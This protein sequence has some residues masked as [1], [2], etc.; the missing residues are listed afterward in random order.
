[1][2]QGDTLIDGIHFMQKYEKSYDSESSAPDHWRATGW[3]LGQ[4]GDKLYHYCTA[5]TYYGKKWMFMDLDFSLPAGDSI[6]VDA[7]IWDP[8]LYDIMAVSDTML[9]S[10]TDRVVRHYMKVKSAWH[11]FLTDDIWIEGIGSVTTGVDYAVLGLTIGG[12][13]QLAKC[14]VG[15]QI[16]YDHPFDQQIPLMVE[17]VVGNLKDDAVYDLQGRCLSEKPRRGLYIQDGRKY[18]AD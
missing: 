8:W 1:M 9:D 12:F 11:E 14:F 3:Y 5:D 16:L 18:V 2:L 6:E 17:K 13:S 4:D 7:N 10:S 15:D